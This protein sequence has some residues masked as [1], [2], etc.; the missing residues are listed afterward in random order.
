M[1]PVSECPH[2][3]IEGLYPGSNSSNLV[4]KQRCHVF[5]TSTR[6]SRD[7]LENADHHDVMS[8]CCPLIFIFS[9][10]TVKYELNFNILPGVIVNEVIPPSRDNI[11]VLFSMFL[12]GK[13]KFFGFDAHSI[14]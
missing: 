12:T 2:K 14:C 3:F 5:F 11:F 7:E 1:S 6:Y 4:L 9:I 10:Q 8:I 13:A